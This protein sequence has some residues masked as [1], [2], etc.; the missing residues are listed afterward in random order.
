M[1]V[2]RAVGAERAGQTVYVYEWPVRLWHW[3][4][5]L[6]ITVLAATGWLIGTAALPT[7]AGE[8]ID[9]FWFGYLR[10]AHFAAAQLFAVGLLGRIYW[11]FAGNRHAHQIF[12]VPLRDAR[13]WREVG[14]QLAWY[15]FLRPLPQRYLGHNPLAQLAIFFGFVLPAVFMLATGFALYSEGQG[16]GGW[17]DRAFG[18]LLPLLGGSQAV[19]TWHR[20]GMWALVCFSIA[21]VYMVLREDLLSRQTIIDAMVTGWRTFRR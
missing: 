20:L 17:H 1:H 6:C 14:A 8:A 16:A 21:H 18:W 2:E 15:A 7:P 10:F 11:A 5:A 3:L 12:F 19:H 13:F 9:H 4:N